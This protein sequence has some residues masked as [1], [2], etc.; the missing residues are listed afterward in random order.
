MD[1]VNGFLFDDKL[2]IFCEVSFF[3]LKFRFKILVKDLL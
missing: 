3:F 1:E 2:I